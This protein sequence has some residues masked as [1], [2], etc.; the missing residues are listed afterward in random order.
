MSG[1][2]I[3]IG[4][5]DGLSDDPLAGLQTGSHCHVKNRRK[6]GGRRR[7]RR[8]VPSGPPVSVAACD[9]F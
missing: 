3:N 6:K 8:L 5:N 4:A 7:R 2:Y 9:L 1:S